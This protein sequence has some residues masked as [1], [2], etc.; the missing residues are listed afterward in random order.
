MLNFCGE[1]CSFPYNGANTV[2]PQA[3]RDVLSERRIK[4]K[5]PVPE[6]SQKLKRC[7]RLMEA[8]AEGKR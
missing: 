5:M 4:L 3:L 6:E 1:S 8:K 2:A 7:S